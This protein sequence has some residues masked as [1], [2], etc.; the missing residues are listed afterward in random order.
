M[1]QSSSVLS[2]PFAFVLFTAVRGC[3][4]GSFQ[5]FFK[6]VGWLDLKAYQD[7]YRNSFATS[8]RAVQ[9]DTSSAVTAD[10][11]RQCLI[12]LLWGLVLPGEN[13]AGYQGLQKKSKHSRTGTASQEPVPHFI[14]NTVTVREN[15]RSQPPSHFSC[16]NS[17]WIRIP[18]G[19]GQ[20]NREGTPSPQPL[21]KC[22]NDNMAAIVAGK[23]RDS[24]S[25]FHLSVP[26]PHPKFSD[27]GL[28][29]S[30]LKGH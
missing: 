15:L 10:K 5:L 20:E 1:P 17:Y 18:S 16:S 27:F 26:N 4:S 21:T 6:S 7:H 12:Q 30:S 8:F 2:H 25:F 23:M 22:N 28:Q 19:F 29:K 14:P 24:Y 9:P 11:Q 13:T 3:I